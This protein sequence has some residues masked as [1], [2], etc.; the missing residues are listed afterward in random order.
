MS[1]TK[2]A[3]IGHPNVGKSTLFNRL[4]G[5]RRAIVGDEPGITR[6]RVVAPAPTFSL[7][8]LLT[9]VFGGV[10]ASIT[11]T[12]AVGLTAAKYSAAARTRK[13]SRPVIFSAL[14]GA[15]QYSRDRSA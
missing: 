14:G 6:D 9:N 4:I 5:H 7:Y 15:A 11:F 3:I 10:A 2:V 12:N 8:R 1:R 13:V